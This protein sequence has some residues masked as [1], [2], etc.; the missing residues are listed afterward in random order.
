MGGLLRVRKSILIRDLIGLLT[1][2]IFTAG[3]N[4]TIIPTIANT[5]PPIVTPSPEPTNTSTPASTATPVP[6]P[7]LTPP[8]VLSACSPLKDIGLDELYAITSNPFSFTSAFTD[9]GHPAVDLAFFTY[10]EFST[11]L[12]HPVQALLPGK[13]TLVVNDRFPY[14]NMVMIETP[15]ESI[16]PGLLSSISLPT[17]IPQ[18]NIAAFSSCDLQMEPLTWDAEMKSIYTLYA[19][20]ENDLHV[21]IGDQVSC[22][23]EIGSVGL[24]GNTVAEHLHL[25]VRVGPANAG[26]STIA[27]FREDATPRERYNYCIWSLSGNFQAIDPAVFWRSV[28]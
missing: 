15:L 18:E 23:Q 26:F 8:P 7:T 17:P 27:T 24:S 1:L 4:T 14:G 28:P 5:Q 6:E 16:S 25:E 10:K 12:G 9:T 22:G 13:V 3:C 20:L 11:F 21:K 19:H 2:L